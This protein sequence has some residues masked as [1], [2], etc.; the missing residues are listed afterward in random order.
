MKEGFKYK[1]NNIIIVYDMDK[2]LVINIYVV[3]V[4]MY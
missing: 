4:G 3:Y 1:S 2:K